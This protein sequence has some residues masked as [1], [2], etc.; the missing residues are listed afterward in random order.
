MPALHR[1]SFAVSC[2]LL[3]AV[4]CGTSNAADK[5]KSDEKPVFRAAAAKSNITPAIGG[6]IIGGF[7]PAPSKHIHD[8]LHAR[9]LVLDD[10]RTKIALVVCDLLGVHRLVSDEARRIIEERTGIPKSHVMVSGTHTHSASSALGT[11]RYVYNPEIDE[12]QKFVAR[13]IADGVQR[14]VNTLRPAELAYGSI[15]VQEHVFNRRWFL[16]PGTMPPNPFGGTDL[17]KM[18]PGQETRT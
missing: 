11:D 4:S 1:L 14:C 12:Y 3:A 13:R 10:G 6:D 5:P 7:S 15:D 16:R 17:V 18:N 8:E 9:C 2:L